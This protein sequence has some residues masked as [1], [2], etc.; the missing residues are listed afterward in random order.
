MSL[1]FLKMMQT[2][3]L[4]WSCLDPL[5]QPN[6]SGPFMAWSFCSYFTPSILISSGCLGAH[7]YFSSW[8]HNS[9][10]N[11]K[12]QP[13]CYFATIRLFP[14]VLFLVGWNAVWH[15]QRRSIWK[16]MMQWNNWL[17]HAVVFALGA[18]GDC[19]W[20]TLKRTEFRVSVYHL[21]DRFPVSNTSMLKKRN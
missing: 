1:I 4:N 5:M 14:V 17:W 18:A 2:Q 9:K 21:H 12:D 10:R 3:R 7:L 13:S 11:L 16:V 8:I 19:F 6:L 15:Q 20:L